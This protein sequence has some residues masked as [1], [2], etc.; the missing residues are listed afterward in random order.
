MLSLQNNLIEIKERVTH[1]VCVHITEP[2]NDTPFD[3][4]ANKENITS[5]SVRQVNVCN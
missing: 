1:V 2:I 5:I 4:N 3:G